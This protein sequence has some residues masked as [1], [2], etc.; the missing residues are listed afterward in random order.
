M[1][2]LVISRSDEVTTDLARVRV[3]CECTVVADQCADLGETPADLDH[4]KAAP[5][6]GQ[7]PIGLV[8]ATA[9]TKM[10]IRLLSTTPSSGIERYN[11]TC[12]TRA[13]AQ[14]GET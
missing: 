5:A 7:N 4:V 6:L 14:F 9:D 3:W 13:A 2:S 10:Q 12:T 11:G 1:Q 8:H